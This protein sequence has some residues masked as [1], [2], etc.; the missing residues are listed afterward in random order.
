M[1]GTITMHAP[2]PVP[3]MHGPQ[4]G[5]RGGREMLMTG[6]DQSD[7]EEGGVGQPGTTNC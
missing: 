6:L 3:W 2:T 7:H 1:I 4:A 5:E